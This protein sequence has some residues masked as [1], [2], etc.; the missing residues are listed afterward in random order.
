MRKAVDLCIQAAKNCERVLDN[1][2][3]KCPVR[4]F[5]DNSVDLELRFWIADP[6]NGVAN[7][8]SMVYLEIWDLF[9]QHGVEIPYPQRDIHIKNTIPSDFSKKVLDSGDLSEM[10]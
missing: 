1:P 5:G 6:A 9:K 10:S 7:I 2:E 3:P 4:G 8:K